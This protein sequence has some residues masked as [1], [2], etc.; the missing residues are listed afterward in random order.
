MHVESESG[1]FEVDS[2][3]SDTDS[4]RRNVY[5]TSAAGRAQKL[6]DLIVQNERFN[7]D[8]HYDRE[9]PQTVYTHCGSNRYYDR[10]CWK[11]L[12]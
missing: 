7:Q 8:G 2:G 11:R 10:G 4:D 3:G 6:G 1:G 5:M 9:K 12:T